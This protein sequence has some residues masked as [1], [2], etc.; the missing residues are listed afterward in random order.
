[1]DTFKFR[2]FVAHRI[3]EI[4]E[5]TN[6]GAWRWLPSKL[7]VADMATRGVRMTEL[8]SDSRWFKA[9]DFLQA[10][11]SDWPS[12]TS[13]ADDRPTPEVLELKSEFVGNVNP[14]ASS[15]LPDVTRFSSFSRLVRSAA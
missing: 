2:P 1:M 13:T 4:V 14:S 7:N 8:I 12:E 5:L 10:S 9:P 15:G 6:V 11:E 3:G